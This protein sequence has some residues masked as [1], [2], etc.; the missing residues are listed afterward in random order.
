MQ[1]QG[2]LVREQ[3]VEFAIIVVKPE[4]LR[5]PCEG[6]KMIAFGRRHFGRETV[7]MAQDGRG[8]PSYWGRRDIVRFLAGISMS[9]IPWRQYT[10][11]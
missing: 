10:L 7:L 6:D 4:V 2:A 1:F 9:R 8:T 5:S 11:N 3:G